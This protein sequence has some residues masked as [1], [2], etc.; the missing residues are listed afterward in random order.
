MEDAF[1]ETSG[2]GM[3]GLC[4]PTSIA[5]TEPHSAETAA[6]APRRSAGR[7]TAAARS[8]QGFELPEA[9][10]K[11]NFET[12]AY[13]TEA[14]LE[15]PDDPIGDACNFALHLLDRRILNGDAELLTVKCV[16]QRCLSLLSAMPPLS[17]VDTVPLRP[18]DRLYEC[19]D[20]FLS[21]LRQQDNQMLE[22]Q[23][24]I[25]ELI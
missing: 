25:N 7:R 22:L 19:F 17:H 2:V 14:A 15:R 11:V 4:I 24:M 23:T 9:Q 1:I 5:K 18:D 6:M 8:K 16:V 13:K 12:V 20:Q 10:R 21:L 3:S